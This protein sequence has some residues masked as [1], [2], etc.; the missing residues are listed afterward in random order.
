MEKTSDKQ[1]ILSI[2]LLIGVS[3]AIILSANAQNYNSYLPPEVIPSN[4]AINYSAATNNNPNLSKF[5]SEA[6]QPEMYQTP[7]ETR[8][9][10]ANAMQNYN[11]MQNQGTSYNE[12]GNTSNQN[13]FNQ[14]MQGIPYN[15]FNQ[16]QNFNQSMPQNFNQM[17]TLPDNQYNPVP[18]QTQTLSGQP[19]V[20]SV[21]KQRTT[22]GISHLAGVVAGFAA[23]GVALAGM[24][25]PGGYYSAGL[26]GTGMA[27]YGLRNGFR[28]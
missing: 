12:M 24:R 19:L 21:S 7:Q 20:Q 13:T 8:Q 2:G 22:G 27:N 14:G 17:N 1:I 26:L 18:P 10:M 9:V 25:S 4:Q 15:Q 5:G 6:A 11:A 3:P 28:F 16:A 23:S